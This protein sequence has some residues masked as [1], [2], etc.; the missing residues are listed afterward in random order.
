MA[1]FKKLKSLTRRIGM[2]TSKNS[3]KRVGIRAQRRRIQNKRMSLLVVD[4]PEADVF[5][6]SFKGCIEHRTKQD[7]IA[8]KKIRFQS[9]FIAFKERMIQRIHE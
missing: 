8:L 1:Y 2:P 7:F 6:L 4:I 3:T 9:Y 5:P